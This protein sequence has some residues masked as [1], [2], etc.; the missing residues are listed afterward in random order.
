KVEIERDVNIQ[1]SQPRVV[2]LGFIN[3][4]NELERL[5]Y[6][7]FH[8]NYNLKR[9]IIVHSSKF[10]PDI[11]NEITSVYVVSETE[12]A[13]KQWSELLERDEWLVPMVVEDYYGPHYITDLSLATRYT[14]TS[15][16]GKK[17][18]YESTKN[19]ELTLHKKEQAYKRVSS[20][21]LRSVMINA[22]VL[23]QFDF[24]D[25]L[26]YLNTAQIEYPEAF[27]IDEFNYCR[28][29][30]SKGLAG[31]Q[32]AM[33]NDVS[34]FSTG[35][36]IA[37]LIKRSERISAEK[38]RDNVLRFDALM[39]SK[40]FTH[41]PKNTKVELVLQEGHLIV[42]SDL[43]N[44]KHEYW[45][46]NKEFLPE[47]LAVKNGRLRFSLEATPSLN[48]QVVWFF[49]D[50]NGKK[51]GHAIKASDTALGVEI[52][53]KTSVIRIALRIYGKGTAQINALHLGSRSPGP[54]EILTK[55]DYL[56]VDNEYPS[57]DDIYRHVFVHRRVEAYIESG[58][59]VDVFRIRPE[60]TLGYHKYENVECITGS[61]D[62]LHSLLSTGRYKTVIV[63]FLDTE[64]WRVLRHYV[65]SMRVIVWVHGSEVQPYHRRKFNYKTDSEKVKAKKKSEQRMALWRELFTNIHPNLHFVFVSKYF[66]EEVMEDIGLR[67]PEDHYSI[68]HNPIN[69]N[70]FTYIPKTVEQRKK[71]LSIRPYS[72]MK[73]A[74][75]LSVKAILELA[76]KPWFKEMEFR[77]IGD[78]LLFEETLA[79]LRKFD[80]VI[81]EKKF[82]TQ[83]DIAL[84]HKE[85]GIFLVPTR[86][87]SQ[88]VSRDEAM[89]S[90]LV[91][92][93]N[94]VAAIPEF[95]D[96]TCGILAEA[97]DHKELA[98]GIE[99]L[100]K[101][102]ELFLSMSSAAAFRVRKQADEKNI[103]DAELSLI[104]SNKNKSIKLGVSRGL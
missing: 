77:I 12:I 62:N 85:Y 83:R 56:V 45:E 50:K 98:N 38:M 34:E 104:K 3:N 58:A 8:Q 64:K 102:S 55:G 5:L 25:R 95:V 92:V 89:A 59:K 19:K 78:G 32:R 57:L 88:G 31:S 72:S 7:Y 43:P 33:I 80:N 37:D 99:R 4:Q 75:D 29:V 74:N 26:E 70:L 90:G 21:A 96:D 81:I 87:D 46:G 84:L 41:P 97:E 68:I 60:A 73:Y 48:L 67:L 52:P 91:P 10:E 36:S 23:D 24:N 17:A 16:I 71:V 101:D 51:I 15:V 22:D 82:L 61:A 42:S 20:L 86:M 40:L 13:G 53:K 94:S 39:L 47:D 27:S 103:I 30:C 6:N 14:K 49:I 35:I 66:A 28:N 69:T 1:N 65:D 2:V 11:T 100:V 63:H 9:L 44:G 54:K 76:N 79:P 93:T 18:Y